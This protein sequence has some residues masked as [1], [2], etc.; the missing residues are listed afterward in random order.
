[1]QVD[2]LFEDMTGATLA[3][4][5]AARDGYIGVHEGWMPI[6]EWWARFGVGG[7]SPIHPD[8][9]QQTLH[10]LEAEYFAQ[11]MYTSC[12]LFI[13]D[14]DR[15]EPRNDIAAAR[16]AISLV[17][18]ATGRDLQAD[19]VRQ[20]AASRSWRTG[21]MG[22]TLYAQLPPVAPALLPAPTPVLTLA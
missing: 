19:F 13:E 15:L 6:E 17:W 8:D 2:T 21:V 7:R 5:W 16:R 12:G 18:Q 4:P 3:D 1:V 9:T 14:L 11:C 22:D 10:L 20:L